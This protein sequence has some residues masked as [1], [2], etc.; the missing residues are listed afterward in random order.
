M[1]IS[2]QLSAISFQLFSALAGCVRAFGL[3]SVL[4]KRERGGWI[5]Q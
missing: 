4:G 3:D 5:A 2:F 1:E